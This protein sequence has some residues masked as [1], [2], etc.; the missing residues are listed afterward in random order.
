MPDV[1]QLEDT[2]TEKNSQIN[3]PQGVAGTK[4][5][6]VESPAFSYHNSGTEGSRTFGSDLIAVTDNYGATDQ[7]PSFGGN[8][9]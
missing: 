1:D 3:S 2:I 4:F 6:A 7:S 9:F 5:M 8:N